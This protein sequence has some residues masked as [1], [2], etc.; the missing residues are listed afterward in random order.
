ME[1]IIASYY[2][3]WFMCEGN[4]EGV[5]MNKDHLLPRP[6]FPTMEQQL[7]VKFPK[8]KELLKDSYNMGY[9][10][11]KRDA[12]ESARPLTFLRK[13]RDLRKDNNKE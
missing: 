10:H 2:Y 5:I 9:M 13:Q 8:L 12:E 11:G 4:I 7:D 3:D 6:V 1:I